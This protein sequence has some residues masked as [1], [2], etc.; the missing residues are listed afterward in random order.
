MILRWSGRFYKVL[1]I[2]SRG[3]GNYIFECKDLKTKESKAIR[4]NSSGLLEAVDHAFKV[5]KKS[6][7][8]FFL[9]LDNNGRS[10]IL[11]EE[12]IAKL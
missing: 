12:Q 3:G 6:K 8:V 10:A 4:F 5:M 7:D 11:T 2:R 9:D 1:S